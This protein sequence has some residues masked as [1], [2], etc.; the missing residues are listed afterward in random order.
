LNELKREEKIWGTMS[1]G[2]VV[3]HTGNG[4]GKTTAALG[5]ALRAIGQGM[6]VLVVQFIK[7]SK[8]TG[9]L[10]IAQKLIPQLTIVPMGGGFFD[11]NSSKAVEREKRKVA[12]AFEF[13]KLNTRLGKYNLIILDEIN[14]AISYGLINIEKVLL[15][16]KEKPKKMHIVLTGRDAKKKIID[17]ADIV[18]EMKEVKHAFKKGTKAQK[19]IEF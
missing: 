19:G 4:K 17:Q 10:K 15:L 2:L 3:V 5:L 1:N 13:V 16:I 14:Y 9:E 11:K 7:S 18:T 6:Q 12:K 8:N